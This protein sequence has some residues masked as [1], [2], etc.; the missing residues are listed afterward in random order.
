MDIAVDQ[1]LPPP[2]AAHAMGVE[3]AVVWLPVARLVLRDDLE[4]L[5]QLLVAQDMRILEQDLDLLV[6]APFRERDDSAQPADLLVAVDDIQL[7]EI[8]DA[9]A[10]HDRH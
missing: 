2:V 8:V 5:G 4:D 7:I 1:S 9:L 6:P 3:P 10:E